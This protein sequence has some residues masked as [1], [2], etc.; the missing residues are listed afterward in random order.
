MPLTGGSD[1]ATDF[2]A[3]LASHVAVLFVNGT[4]AEQYSSI[5]RDAVALV[6]K[7]APDARIFDVSRDRLIRQA[8]CRASQWDFFPQLFVAGEFIGGA[9]IYEEFFA[10]DEYS[11]ILR[12]KGLNPDTQKIGKARSR[13]AGTIWRFAYDSRIGTLL[14]AASDGTIRVWDSSGAFVDHR[15][16]V[17]EGW[18]NAVAID[19]QRGIGYAG[20]T[21][22]S[23]CAIDLVRLVVQDRKI[24]HHRWVNDLAISGDGTSVWSVSADLFGIAWKVADL[25]ARTRTQ[26]H[27]HCPWCV[28][29]AIDESTLA[30]G[31][32]D[33]T[34]R[35]W[36][37]LTMELKGEVRLH[38]GGV[39]AVAPY[40][41]GFCSVSAD[42]TARIFSATGEEIV[43]FDGHR[44]RVWTASHIVPYEL[45]ASAGGDGAVRIWRAGSGE[46]LAAL[47]FQ[48]MPIAVQYVP[49]CKSLA[50][51]HDTGEV[52][53][54]KIEAVIPGISVGRDFAGEPPC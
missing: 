45:F 4:R 18:V 24:E 34:I 37:P 3:L 26:V 19:G 14:G 43:V 25:E 8:A 52:T 38:H 33:G 32:S 15:I 46:E 21:D 29:L 49:N 1:A 31:A 5:T 42:G 7:N 12:G 17:S 22:G 40:S 20:L 36:S 11:R 51:S 2:K 53:W 50:V 48:S 35:L 27:D 10:S 54:H 16:Q 39:T 9:M 47:N 30:T 41:T 28:A 44:E 23:V 6:Q 13:R